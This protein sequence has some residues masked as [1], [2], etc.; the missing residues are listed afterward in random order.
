MPSFSQ[1]SIRELEE[2]VEPLQVL[3]Y[4]AIRVIDFTVLE[5]H[6][7][8][9]E[10]NIAFA[11][12]TSKL[13]WPLGKHNSKP[14][15]ALDFAPYPID[16]RDDEKARQRFI[17]VAGIFIGLAHVKGIKIRWGGDW[18]RNMDT[19]DENFR[20]LGHIEVVD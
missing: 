9:R 18:N 2:C 4:E 15:K 6:R 3:A 11:N 5:G 20:D 10:Q 19:R 17:L 8:E 7:G 1:A 16:W 13:P 12:G 14:S